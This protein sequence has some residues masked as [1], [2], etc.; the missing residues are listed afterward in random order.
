MATDSASVLIVDDHATL[1]DG[2]GILLGSEPDL[3]VAG[4][5]GS[6]AEALQVAHDRPIDLAIVD[7]NLP[8]GSGVDL[9]AMLARRDPPITSIV[10]SMYSEG[11]QVLK[12]FENGAMGYVLK[13]APASELLTGLSR[14]RQGQRFLG[15]GLD[16]QLLLQL[17]PARP[18]PAIERLSPR[19]I[20]V[21][22][23][24]VAG[25]TSRDIGEAMHLSVKTV[26]T[27]RHRVMQKLGIPHLPGLVKFAI[28]EGLTDLYD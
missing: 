10:L 13:G 7:I 17:S 23:R 8:D 5:A 25:E 27:Y 22:R 4:Y 2:L 24:V 18:R 14:V 28:R 19:E 15:A 20:E 3:R 12:A 16:G 6:V 26:D 9:V 1:R 21:L 11:A